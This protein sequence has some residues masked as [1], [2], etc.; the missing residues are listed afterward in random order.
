MINVDSATNIPMTGRAVARRGNNA[1][2]NWR[3]IVVTAKTIPWMKMALFEY[4]GASGASRC[5]INTRAASLSLGALTSTT[6]EVI[7]HSIGHV[8][9]ARKKVPFVKR[10]QIIGRTRG[11]AA[12]LAAE[13]VYCQKTCIGQALMP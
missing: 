13:I 8:V 9:S 2:G 7:T 4:H 12:S 3:N 11:E 10:Y 6:Q 1:P 5:A